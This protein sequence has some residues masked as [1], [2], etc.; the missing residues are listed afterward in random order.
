MNTGLRRL[1]A[2]LVLGAIAVVC[3]GAGCTIETEDDDGGT[4]GSGG[5]GGAGG[6]GG[7]GGIGGIG[8]SLADVFADLVDGD[9]TDIN[10]VGCLGNCIGEPANATG[11]PNFETGP[12]NLT[13]ASLGPGGMLGL[14]F[15][16]E[17]CVVD[18]DRSTPDIIVYE[19]G[20]I[21]IEDFS[22]R[23]VLAGEKDL[24]V[25]MI[26][27]NVSDDQPERHLDLT[28]LIDG[29]GMVERIQIIDIDG[30]PGEPEEPGF[31]EGW[32]ADIDAVACFSR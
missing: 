6:I 8:G 2:V 31:E 20:G 24:V 18:D 32:G 9:L 5:T 4:P 3:S 21:Q 25:G 14:V 11:A 12:G 26:D 17:L 29:P 22:L 16:D 10:D 28:D 15:V 23:V 30:P 19:R 13:H 27:S 7:S 1:K